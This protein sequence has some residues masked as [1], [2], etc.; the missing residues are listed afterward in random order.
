MKGKKNETSNGHWVPGK[1]RSIRELVP[2]RQVEISDIPP[3]TDYLRSSGRCLKLRDMKP[4]TLS[5][6]QMLLDLNP[7]YVMKH[8]RTQ[9]YKVVYGR[10]LFELAAFSL[11]PSDSITVRVLKGRLSEKEVSMLAY[12][13]LVI[14]SMLSSLDVSYA[15]LYEMI[16]PDAPHN[17]DLLSIH[18]KGE[19]A[20]AFG[21]SRSLLSVSPKKQNLS[22]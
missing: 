12:L 11:H 22:E 20:R 21:V 4:L 18:T 14:A 2:V 5:A 1:F 16:N 6:L 13:D 19:F 7:P 9:K 10:L 8:G 15:E 17:R 3:N